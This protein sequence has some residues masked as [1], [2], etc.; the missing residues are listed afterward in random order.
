MFDPNKN[1]LV[2][3]R[4]GRQQVIKH[5]PELEHVEE[6]NLRNILIASLMSAKELGSRREE[7]GMVTAYLLHLN[8]FGVDLDVELCE[9]VERKSGRPLMSPDGKMRSTFF[10]GAYKPGERYFGELNHV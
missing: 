9:G 5:I 1:Y 7:R 6:R 4:L 2:L 10:L 8:N 3:T